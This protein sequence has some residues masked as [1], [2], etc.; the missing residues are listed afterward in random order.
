M[1]TQAICPYGNNTMGWCREQ[2]KKL[3]F[4]VLFFKIL[5]NN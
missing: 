4:L 1:N 5:R 3:V 2:G